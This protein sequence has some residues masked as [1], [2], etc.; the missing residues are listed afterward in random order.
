MKFKVKL[1]VSRVLRWRLIVFQDYKYQTG[2]GDASTVIINFLGCITFGAL[3]F[4]D[5]QAAGN[6]LVQREKV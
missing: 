3:F 4:L 6:R 2:D 1:K 5:R